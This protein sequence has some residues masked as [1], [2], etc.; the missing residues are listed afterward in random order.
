MRW[1][2]RSICEI[3]S[4]FTKLDFDCKNISTLIHQK[5]FW[6]TCLKHASRD[7]LV[8]VAEDED[9]YSDD[10]DVDP[11]GEICPW[12][13]WVLDQRSAPLLTL[14]WVAEV[15][16]C[17]VDVSPA[18]IQSSWHQV[19][20]WWCLCSLCRRISWLVELE[21]REMCVDPGLE[22]DWHWWHWW[23]GLTGSDVHCSQD[24]PPSCHYLSLAL[25]L[26]HNTAATI[27]C[28][29]I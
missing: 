21:L 14:G 7:D 23:P 13:H 18:V 12:Q 25:S 15:F 9:D 8:L 3:S 26:G 28:S 16:W 22:W 27:S 29:L 11:P 20:S 6:P 5:I 2:F 10:D 24:W 19:C 17:L 4:D 1:K